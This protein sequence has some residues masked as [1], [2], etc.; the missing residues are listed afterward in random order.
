[1]SDSW[2]LSGIVPLS[3]SSYN[4]TAFCISGKSGKAFLKIGY[5]ESESGAEI[6]ALG[7]FNCSCVIKPLAVDIEKNAILLPRLIPGTP[8]HEL[9]NEDTQNVIAAS[10]MSD[11]KSPQKIKYEYPALTKWFKHHVINICYFYVF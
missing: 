8:L 3:N 4:Y 5:P 1:L 9:N 6:A 2:H 10:L 11:L 7:D